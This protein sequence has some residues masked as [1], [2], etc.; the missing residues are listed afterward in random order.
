MI[1]LPREHGAYGQL[2]FPLAAALLAYGV[3]RGALFV[4]AAAVAGFLAHEPVSILIGLRG[5]RALR[6]RQSE[7]A[8]WLAWW[9]VLSAAAATAAVKAMPAPVRWWLLLPVAPAILLAWATVRGREKSWYGEVAA[10]CAFSLVAVPMA[11]AS[12]ASLREALTLAVPFAVLFV[13]STLAVRVVILR[14]RGGG[15]PGAAA[16]TRRAALVVV[17]ASAAAVAGG[18]AME[19]LTPAAVVASL[20]A[21]LGSTVL[22]LRPPPPARLRAVGWTL[23]GLSLLTTAIIVAAAHS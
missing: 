10:A 7:A 9:G 13:T 15:G 21:V 1:P 2:G 19:I 5:G 11:L 18:V 14:V 23:V 6:E 3:S 8:R 20:P 22:A 4:L 12:G 17:A 16:A